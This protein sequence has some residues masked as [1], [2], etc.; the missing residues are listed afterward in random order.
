ME[1]GNT[2]NRIMDN[3]IS[4]RNENQNFTNLQT[5]LNPDVAANFNNLNEFQQIP[6]AGLNQITNL[7]NSDEDN[8]K[9]EDLDLDCSMNSTDRK[10]KKPFME[11]V[12]D[13]VCIKC[14]NLNFSFRVMCNRCQM[15]KYESERLTEQYLINYSNYIKFNEVMQQRILMNHP[16]N[17]PNNQ[18]FLMNSANFPANN[19]FNKDNNPDFAQGFMD[20]NSANFPRMPNDLEGFSSNDYFQNL[21]Y[22][23]NNNSNNY[24]KGF[25]NR[26]EDYDNQLNLMMENNKKVKVNGQINVSQVDFKKDNFN[27]YQS[28]G[29]FSSNN[30]GVEDS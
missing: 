27:N 17:M 10:N 3:L 1:N 25:A 21:N 13:W 26:Q 6:N 2:P 14:K 11:R 24:G 29:N 7:N 28:K 4:M 20:D 18:A 30:F 22:P 8:S 16:M 12:G 5:N 19:F 15:T 23:F 9:Q